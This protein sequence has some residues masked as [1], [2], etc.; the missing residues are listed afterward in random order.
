MWYVFLVKLDKN[1][2]LYNAS[3][4]LSGL[5]EWEKNEKFSLLNVKH[6]F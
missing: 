3:V 5:D 4:P 2:F 6:I 1:V